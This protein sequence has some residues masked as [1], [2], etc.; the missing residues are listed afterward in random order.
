MKKLW[1]KL[2]HG[3]TAIEEH[4][5]TNEPEVPKILLSIIGGLSDLN[6]KVLQELTSASDEEVSQDSNLVHTAGYIDF[7]GLSTRIEVSAVKKERFRVVSFPPWG[8]IS[9]DTDFV[10][11]FF[12]TWSKESFDELSFWCE[13][14]TKHNSSN[15]KI[16]LMAWT[17]PDSEAR[18][19][20]EEEGKAFAQQLE[21]IYRE[22]SYS[23]NWKQLISELIEE[24]SVPSV[25]SARSAPALQ[26]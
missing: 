11:C 3:G 9:R 24:T 26:E 2:I 18:V 23:T 7:N 5:D 13:F 22:V 10:F 15:S 17:K 4:D 19:I 25:K 6:I 16:F 21:I 12:G 20:T 1:R 8:T 14:A